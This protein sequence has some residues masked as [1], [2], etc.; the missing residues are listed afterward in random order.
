MYFRSIGSILGGVPSLKKLQGA[1][2]DDWIDR[3]NHVWTVFLFALFAIVVST[4]QFVGDPIHCWCPAEFTG[5]YVD[6]AKSYCWIKNT[7]YIPMQEVI[8][9]DHG[10]REQ[11]E[12]TYYQ[13]VPLILLFQAFMFKFPNIM[14]RV[15]NGGSGINLDKVVDMAEKTQMGS[16]DDRK[17]TIDHISKY[18]DRW[19]ETHREYKYNIIVRAKQ[20]MARICCFFCNKRAG[21]YLVAFYLF[22]KVLYVVNVIGQFFLLNAFLASDYS[23][24]GFEVMEMLANEGSWKESPRFP[25]VTLCD[26]RIRQLQNIQ[27]WTVQCVLPI[28]LFN[29]KIFIFIWFWL[30]IVATLSCINMLAWFYRIVLKRNRAAYIKKYLKINNELHTASDKKTC[31]KFA[32]QYLRDD[33][34]F[35]LRVISKNSTDLVVTDLVQNMWNMYKKKTRPTEPNEYEPNDYPS[36]KEALANDN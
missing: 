5:S 33:G 31:V 22:V 1:S 20:K 29:E 36:E 18:L 34:V 21:T 30:V 4:G 17:T 12:I 24:Y 7:Y 10:K 23:L 27:R 13:W 8:P 3:L 11:E 6:Y 16:P 35:V 32:D 15:F 9:T 26:F 14:W 28:N 2:N 19:L 25:R